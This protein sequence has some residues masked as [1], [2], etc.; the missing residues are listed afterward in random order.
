MNFV[1]SFYRY[2]LD[3]ILI[4]TPG[5]ANSE[6]WRKKTNKTKKQKQ[7]KKKKQTRKIFRLCFLLNEECPKLL[8]SLGIDHWRRKT[9][10]L[11]YSPWKRKNSSAVKNLPGHHTAPN[12][13]DTR[14]TVMPLSRG[15]VLV[16][17]YRHS[18]RMYLMKEKQ[19]G[20]ISTGLKRWPFKFIKHLA[21]TT[22]VSPSPAGPT[23]GCPLNFLY[24]INLKFWVR[25]PNGCSEVQSITFNYKI[26]TYSP[27][28]TS[29]YLGSIHW[30]YRF[31]CLSV[32][33]DSLRPTNNLSVKQ[34]RVFQGWTS[35]KLG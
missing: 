3:Q 19:G 32:W 16:F 10:P 28:R 22:C 20:P 26:S 25:A 12:I 23:G 18:T 24:L 35:T 29:V 30:F 33:F 27:F 34:G 17:F 14:H 8:S 5:S 6:F 13:V 31:S 7:Y 1:L 11:R 21:D 15:Q 9:I 4:I 2:W